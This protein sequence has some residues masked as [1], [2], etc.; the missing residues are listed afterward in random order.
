M[1]SGSS[2]KVK[3]A[4]ESIL[5]GTHFWPT[6]SSSVCD[7]DTSHHFFALKK[8]TLKSTSCMYLHGSRDYHL[9]VGHWNSNQA[10]GCT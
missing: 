8:A 7:I 6:M 3:V 2:S 9:K 4:Y 5:R 1:V 10:S